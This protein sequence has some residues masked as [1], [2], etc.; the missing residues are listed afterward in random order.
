MPPTIAPEA[1]LIQID[2]S[3]A[4]IGRN[5]GVAV[6]IVGDTNAVVEQ[7]TSEAEKHTWAELPWLNQLRAERKA[8]SEALNEMA[9]RESPLHATYVHKEI[10]RHLNDD[11]FLV[12]DGGDFCHFGRAYIPARSART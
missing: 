6:G 9:V 12:F 2:P 1:K 4:E 11:D 5:R 3:F 7:L 8:Q 10:A